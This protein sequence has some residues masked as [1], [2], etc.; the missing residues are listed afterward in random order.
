MRLFWDTL[1]TQVFAWVL[2]FAAA[3]GALCAFYGTRG[4]QQ[5]GRDYDAQAISQ[6][7][8]MRDDVMQ[9][10]QAYFAAHAGL[11]DDVQREISENAE[12]QAQTLSDMA[13]ARRSG[14]RREELRLKIEWESLQIDWNTLRG[15]DLENGAVLSQREWDEYLYAHNLQPKEPENACDARNVLCELARGA[16]PL[17]CALMPMLL[18]AFLWGTQRR[19]MRFLLQRPVGRQKIVWTFGGCVLVSALAAVILVFLIVTLFCGALFGFGAADYPVRVADGSLLPM[20]AMLKSCVLPAVGSV[21]FFSGL[22][23]FCGALVENETALMLLNAAV[24]AAC[25]LLG[26]FL[27]DAALYLPPFSGAGGE[28]FWR[29]LPGFPPAAVM[30]AFAAGAVVLCAGARRFAAQDVG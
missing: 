25:A 24:P 21:G 9:Q 4:A 10:T 6:Y 12:K 11:S 17:V 7:F 14:D 16:G 30:L 3:A 20:K 13:M 2:V 1:R 15:E 29:G 18:A 22:G 5:A 27:P 26:R 19:G 8:S 28:A 23:V